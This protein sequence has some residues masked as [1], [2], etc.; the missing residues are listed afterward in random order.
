MLTKKEGNQRI[1]APENI[2]CIIYLNNCIIYKYKYS[3]TTGERAIIIT[4]IV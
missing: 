3:H 2:G 4:N 1:G